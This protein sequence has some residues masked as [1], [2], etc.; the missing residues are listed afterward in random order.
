MN[1]VGELQL[2]LKI[3]E[4]VEHLGLDG[5][6]ES[7]DGLVANDQPWLERERPRNPDPLALATRELVRVA[8]VVLGVEPHALHELTHERLPVS[9]DVVDR[10]RRTDDL[11]DRVTRVERRV[12][13]L[14]DDLDLAPKRPQLARGEVGD[15]GAVEDDA[16]R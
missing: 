5:D 10:K 13:V 15:V 11:P 14:E 16:A 4:Q 9:L 3:G 1:R 6:V 8:V 2:A 7:R 12:G